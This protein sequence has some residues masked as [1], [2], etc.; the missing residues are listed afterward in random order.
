MSG[1]GKTPPKRVAIVGGGLAGLTAAYRL[2][3][4]T[5]RSERAV[6][7]TLF[8]ATDRF[9]GILHS[10]RDGDWLVERGP[11][12][13]QMKPAATALLD[14]LGLAG[15]AIGTESTHRGAMVLHDGRPTRVPAGFALMSPNRPRS[16]ATTP[17][18]DPAGRARAIAEAFV[19][20]HVPEADPSVAAFARRRFG[21][22]A[23]D[24]LIEPLVAGIYTGDGDR[25][26]V[27]ATLPRFFDDEQTAGSLTRA[28]ARRRDDQASGGVGPAAAE[29]SSGARYGEFVSFPD[30]VSELTDTLATRLAQD[31]RVALRPS[32]PVRTLSRDGLR[33]RVET[34]RTA[35]SFDSVIAAVP[36]PTASRL[37]AAEPELAAAIAAIPHASSAVVVSRYRLEDVADPLPAFGLVVPSAAGRDVIAISYT[38]RKF[39]GRAPDRHVT[40]R[41]FLG[42]VRRPELCDLDDDRLIEIVA[43]EHAE[44]LGAK[45]P[46]ASEVVRWP[47]AMPQY[48]VGHLTRVAE[49]ERLL[50][51]RPG[52]YACGLSYRGVGIADVIAD[53]ERTAESIAAGL[54]RSDRRLG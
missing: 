17:L 26:S 12:M 2:T 51:E 35:E 47:E 41:T 14:R 36:G 27:R 50:S 52:L 45:N 24:A 40:L 42:G 48:E 5:D 18:L 23:Y 21:D 19:P 53:A 25:L 7:I 30:G 33:W 49:I 32:E 13:L 15:R 11:D 8:E 44:I 20:P 16:L 39:P 6:E 38:S 37:L 46:L 9:G 43:R 10:V 31:A 34:E 3:E 28:A 22:A 1:D 54:D 29:P 4:L